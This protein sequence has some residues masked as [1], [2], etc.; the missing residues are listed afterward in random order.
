M[1]VNGKQTIIE[2][3][4]G[5]YQTNLDIG[6]T[7]IET[8]KSVDSG[9]LANGNWSQYFPI[10]QEV[11]SGI[12]HWLTN[13]T[14]PIDIEKVKAS[15][16]MTI[17]SD[18]NNLNIG[19]FHLYC[20]VSDKTLS[21]VLYQIQGNKFKVIWFHSRKLTDTQKRYNISDREFLSII[22][23]LKKFQPLLISKNV[24]IYTDLQN[25]T[26][27]IN[28]SND[29]PFTKRQDNYMKY[30]KEF[31]YELRYISGKKNGIADFLYRK[32]DNFQWD[33]SFLNKIK[34]EQIN[35]QWNK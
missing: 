31:D 13:N 12:S 17:H 3:E 15:T 32:Y 16:N 33:E 26:Y 29:I 2:L 14:I 27:I 4:S 1:V 22:D 6:P 34:E 21:G 28:K 18:N 9:S 30:I 8:M 24:S 20:D 11:K 10:P 23:S 19:T 25:L 7:N 5:D 35:S